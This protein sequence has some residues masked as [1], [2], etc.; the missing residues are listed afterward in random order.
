MKVGDLVKHTPWKDEHVSFINKTSDFS[1][2]L[3]IDSREDLY[4][5]YY[6]IAAAGKKHRW[7]RKKELQLIS[8][9]CK[10]T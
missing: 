2:G 9:I 8:E 5:F 3:I 1:R 7:Y 10:K 4:S 6:L